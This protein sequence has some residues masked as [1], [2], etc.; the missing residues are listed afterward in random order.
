MMRSH[1]TVAFLLLQPLIGA[2]PAMPR[3]YLIYQTTGTVFDRTCGELMKVAV[4]MDMVAET[5]RRTREFQQ[6]WDTEGPTYMKTAMTEVGLEFPFREV[7]ATL[8]VCSV[9]SMSSPL[10]I[11][12]TGFLTKAE[13]KQPD[14]LFAFIVYHEL[15]HLYVRH[16]YDTSA[17]RKKYSTEPLQ[18]LN[19]IHVLALEKFAL[20]KLGRS[21][22]LEF[23]DQRYRKTLPPTYRRAWE[24]VNAEGEDALIQELKAQP[25]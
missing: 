10:L 17:L 20:K 18:T 21:S 22:E 9:P 16:V 5:G 12:V 23:V 7:Q 2:T 8:T 11:N 6:R 19:H 14:W 13:R 25:R 3:V 1:L 15:M 4:D 24:I